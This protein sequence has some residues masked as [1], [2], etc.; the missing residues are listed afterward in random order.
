LFFF[1]PKHGHFGKKFK[2]IFSKMLE[3]LWAVW[4]LDSAR[5]FQADFKGWKILNS[6][7]NFALWKNP[8]AGKK[9]WAL[10]EILFCVTLSGI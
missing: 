8:D 7:Q 9:N 1:A 2:T 5:S 6:A 10:L 4:G 3:N